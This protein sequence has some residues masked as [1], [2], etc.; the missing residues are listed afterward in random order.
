[1]KLRSSKVK[2]DISTGSTSSFLF[3]SCLSHSAG[4]VKREIYCAFAPRATLL[5]S[6]VP[7]NFVRGGGGSTN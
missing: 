1:M 7:R 4:H 5:T 3:A 2:A 6:G